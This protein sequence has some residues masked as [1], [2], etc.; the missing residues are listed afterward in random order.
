MSVFYPTY[1]YHQTEA[2][3]GRKFTDEAAFNALGPD[4]VDTPAKF[5]EP[6]PVEEPADTSTKRGRKAK[7]T[8][9]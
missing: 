5:P 8:A 1:R 4:W 9:Q 3:A 6:E 2:P 7:E